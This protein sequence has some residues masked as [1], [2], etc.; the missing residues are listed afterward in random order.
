MT[1]H[2][3]ILQ[4][5]SVNG[6]ISPMEAFLELGITKLSTRIGELQKAG[7]AFD[8]KMTESVDRRGQPVRYMRYSIRRD[9]DE[10]LL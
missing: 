5:L 2:E 7:F 3:A 6:D 9:K 4:Y 1:Q 8:K 10:A